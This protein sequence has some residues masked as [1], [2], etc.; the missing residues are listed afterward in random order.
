MRG[1]PLTILPVTSFNVSCYKCEALQ[2]LFVS[3]ALPGAYIRAVHL[4]RLRE[5]V[6]VITWEVKKTLVTVV[7]DIGL[8]GTPDIYASSHPPLQ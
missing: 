2:C 8:Y 1:A 6:R 3:G 7:S 4:C 5:N